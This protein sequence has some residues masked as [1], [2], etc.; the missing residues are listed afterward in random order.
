VLAG[1]V[2]TGKYETNPQADRAAGTLDTPRVAH[3]AAAA[4][5]LVALARELDTDPATLAIAFALA[6]P[7]VASALTGATH[8]RQIHSNVR[9]PDLLTGLDEAAL[10][11][12]RRI[13]RAVGE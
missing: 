1:G 5:D 3:A 8:P 9:A 11:R 12:L 7:G 2:L 4:G 10:A 6:G 13:G